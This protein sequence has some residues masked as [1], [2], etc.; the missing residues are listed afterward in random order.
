MSPY[1]AAEDAPPPIAD[2]TE[3]VPPP[4]F[5]N[6]EHKFIQTEYKFKKIYIFEPFPFFFAKQKKR[7]RI[8]IG[9]QKSHPKE[10]RH[11]SN[12]IQIMFHSLIQMMIWM[13]CMAVCLRLI[14]VKI[15]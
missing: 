3:Q 11:Q 12:S 9:L 14:T 13:I 1:D 8:E 15:Q 10:M 6:G 5:M 7:R 2:S 4:S